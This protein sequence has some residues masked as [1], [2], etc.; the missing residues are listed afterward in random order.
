[1]NAQKFH[2]PLGAAV[3]TKTTF[4]ARERFLERSG[5]N[6]LRYFVYT[7]RLDEAVENKYEAADKPATGERKGQLRCLCP[8]KKRGQDT[9]NRPNRFVNGNPKP[10]PK[11][12]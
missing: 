10:K 8:D 9:T 12:T 5:E 1:M 2:L 6:L 4:T 7:C 3:L 11:N